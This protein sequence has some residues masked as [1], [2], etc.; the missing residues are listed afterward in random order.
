MSD[1]YEHDCL[2]H[3]RCTRHNGFRKQVPVWRRVVNGRRGGSLK[4]LVEEQIPDAE[5]CHLLIGT[6][7]TAANDNR[8]DC[9]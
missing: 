1:C 8:D 2:H 4:T 9:V 7:N 3:V 5:A 6:K